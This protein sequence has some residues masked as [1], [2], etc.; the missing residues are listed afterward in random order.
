MNDEWGWV[1]LNEINKLIKTELV[2]FAFT[3]RLNARLESSQPCNTVNV[4]TYS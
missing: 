3:R 1:E 4:K 2:L